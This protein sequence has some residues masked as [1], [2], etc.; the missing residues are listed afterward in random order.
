MRMKIINI[1]LK[2]PSTDVIKK[3]VEVLKSGGILVYPTDTCYGLGVDPRNKKAL[4]KLLELKGRLLSKKISV[5]VPDLKM[6]KKICFVNQKQEE[7]LRKYL[8]GPF[9]FILFKKKAKKETLGIR[10]PDCLITQMLA[11]EFGFPYTTTSANLSGQK[12]CYDIGCV[13][14]QFKNKK[15]KPDLILDAGKLSKNPPSTVVDLTCFPPRVLRKGSAVFS[16]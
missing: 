3:A 8:P 4:Q 13:L 10:I 1:N 15:I 11:E 7:I 16:D 5:I 14:S 6:L 2:K 12:E 9:T